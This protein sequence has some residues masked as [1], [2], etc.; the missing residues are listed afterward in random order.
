MRKGGKAGVGRKALQIELPLEWGGSSDAASA[1]E[2]TNGDRPSSAAKPV[3]EGRPGRKKWYSLYD[4]ITALGN[5]WKAWE[6]VRRKGGSPGCDRQTVKQF[7]ADLEANLQRLHEELRAKRYRPKPVRRKAIPK[8]GGGE[9]PLGIPCV[10][11]RVVQHAVREILSPIYEPKFSDASYGFRPGCS[12]HTALRVVE[13]A[14]GAN[15]TWVVDADVTKFFDRVDHEILMDRLNE[16]I[17]D[18]SVLRLIRLFLECGVITEKGEFEATEVG[19]PQ[20]GPLSPLLANIY[21]DPMDHA[22]REQR[23]GLVRYADDFVIFTKTRERAEEAL[24]AVR[25]A[26]EPL[27]LQ[28]HPEK[29]RIA[30]IEKGFDFL[31]YNFFRDKNGRLQKVISRKSR[32]RFRDEIRRRTKRHGGQKHAKPKRCTVY[33]LK[34]NQRIQAMIAE[35]NQ[36]LRDWHPYFRHVRTSWDAMRQLDQFVRKRLRCAISGRNARGRWHKILSNKLL[37]EIGLLTLTDM[38]KPFDT[39]PISLRPAG[40]NRA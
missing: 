14:L 18:G 28:L 8:T 34:R 31:G 30:A 27:K 13:R 33:R 24:E 5:L 15:Y 1:T 26:F 12:Q 38:Q 29:T 37:E 40:V 6:R 9:R 16:R 19:T 39:G 3:E 17:A 21:L 32:Y 23:F 22:L 2:D 25:E 10:R 4:K 20:G 7:G 35:I 36:Y 11:D